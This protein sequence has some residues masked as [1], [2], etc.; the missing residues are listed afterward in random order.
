MPNNLE[1]ARIRETQPRTIPKGGEG[2][3]GSQENIKSEVTGWMHEMPQMHA[4]D[5]T[6]HAPAVARARVCAA[7][8]GPACADTSHA[9]SLQTPASAQAAA[10]ADCTVFSAGEPPVAP[11]HGTF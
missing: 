1:T 5:A 2:V 8:P 3:G 4:Q 10:A 6:G 11:T 7:H 9:T